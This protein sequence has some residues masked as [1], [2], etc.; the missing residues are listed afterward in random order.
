MMQYG[1]RSTAATPRMPV[2]RST[3]DGQW[4]VL[5]ANDG[6]LAAADADGRVPVMALAGNEQRYLLVFR[7]AAKARQFVAS[8]DLVGAEPRMVVRG[9][10]DEL[11]RIARAASVVGVLVDYEPE[12]QQYF[13]VTDL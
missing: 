8:Q 11:V 6:E 10:R 5:V 3:L 2:A 7:N 1:Q 9:N 13:A 12:T 4:V